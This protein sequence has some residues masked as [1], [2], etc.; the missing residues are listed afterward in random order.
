[1]K[2]PVPPFSSG[3]ETV[4]DTNVVS[5]VVSSAPRWSDTGR[6]FPGPQT[7]Y[8]VSPD[9][10]MEWTKELMAPS[11]LNLS[12]SPTGSLAGSNPVPRF[13][14]VSWELFHPVNQG[15]GKTRRPGLPTQDSERELN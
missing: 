3:L 2:I 10:V 14:L 1:M 8:G 6:G 7:L 13:G 11:V 12:L 5:T 15:T 4:D 9:L